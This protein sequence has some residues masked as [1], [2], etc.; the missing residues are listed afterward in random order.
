MLQN[1]YK[2]NYHDIIR[3]WGYSH[4]WTLSQV[5]ICRSPPPSEVTICMKD[6]HSAESNEKLCISFFF[7]YGWLHLQFTATHQVCHQPKKKFFKCG[8][9]HRKDAHWSDYDFLVH[10]YFCI[11]F[12]FWDMVDF[13]NGRLHHLLLGEA[14]RYVTDLIY[15]K[16]TIFQK[17]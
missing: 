2:I 1:V 12:N 7:I 17:L 16:L 8:R 13:T 4:L 14:G 11:I 6:A 5:G 10:N 15:A 3:N 9:I